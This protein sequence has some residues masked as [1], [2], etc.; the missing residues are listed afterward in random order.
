MPYSY[1]EPLGRPDDLGMCRPRCRLSER[2][3]VAH[4]GA[5]QKCRGMFRIWGLVQ[6][7][8][9]QGSGFRVQGFG[10]QGLGLSKNRGPCAPRR[11]QRFR[12]GGGGG[13]GDPDMGQ[14]KGLCLRDVH[15]T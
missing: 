9:V 6:G 14:K 15:L 7:F 1:M 10:V 4:V 3:S 5:S 8:R 11:T 2:M 12:R 13:G